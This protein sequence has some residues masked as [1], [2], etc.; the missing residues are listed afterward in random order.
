MPTVTTY[1]DGQ[2]ISSP[3]TGL[4]DYLSW[5]TATFNAVMCQDDDVEPSA[6]VRIDGLEP[7]SDTDD[8]A[9]MLYSVTY[10]GY[11]LSRAQIIEERSWP[12]D[13]DAFNGYAGMSDC[14]L[15]VY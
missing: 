5:C 11:N 4:L 14:L 7:V 6:C 3:T 15:I 9:P 1:Y 12:D 8:D 2:V 13:L 10:Q